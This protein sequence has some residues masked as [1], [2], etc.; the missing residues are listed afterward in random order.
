MPEKCV[1]R[2]KKNVC[3]HTAVKQYL[4]E[5]VFT[6]DQSHEEMLKRSIEKGA[7]IKLMLLP[8]DFYFL[9]AKG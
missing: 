9:P 8:V 3:A 2:K 6:S 1:L 4:Q 7:P 5:C